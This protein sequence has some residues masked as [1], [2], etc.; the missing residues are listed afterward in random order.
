M[1]ILRR[2][3]YWT[4]IHNCQIKAVHVPSENNVIA[5]S[6]SRGQLEKFREV[7]PMAEETK[8]EVP[9]EFFNLLI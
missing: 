9:Q 5:D 7:A 8:T 1:S 6:L 2:I 4:L 3:V